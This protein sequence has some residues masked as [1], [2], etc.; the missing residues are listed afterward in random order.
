M[1]KDRGI[2]LASLIARAAGGVALMLMSGGDRSIPVGGQAVIEGVLMRGPEH[3]GLVVREPDGKM[4]RK[5]WAGSEW[6]KRGLW[7]LPI[8]RGFANMVE[9]LRVGTRALT[10]SA[11]RA[12][13]EE[14]SFSW[15]ET[16]ITMI[17]AIAMVAGLFI[18]LPVWLADTAAASFGLP[19]VARHVTEG[20][21]RCLVFVGYIAAA[22][23]S[24]DMR[25]VFAYH[26]AEHKTI[27]AWEA[28]LPIGAEHSALCSRIHRRCGTSFLV[29]VAIVSIAI[30]SL[31]ADGPFWYRACGR[32]VLLPLV[33]GVSYEIIR[34]A[35][36]GGAL[37]GALIAPALALQ[38]LTTREPDREM[39]EVA[40]ASLETA[41]DPGAALSEMAD[42]KDSFEAI[43]D[44]SVE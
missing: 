17:A 10:L 20:V 4:W 2:G 38:Y 23:L 5:A 8:A 25:R 42:G 40:S 3:W 35:S 41:L 34:A 24:A 6:M 33:T 37:C 1:S 18:A 16:A 12:L 28:G 15:I 43:E 31:L 19:S 22:G 9:M 7:R 13:G 29:I 11:D 32:I 27:N 44:G 14:E 36:R 39:L 30:F 21:M 26:G